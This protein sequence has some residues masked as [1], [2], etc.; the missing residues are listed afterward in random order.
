M[1][2]LKKERLEDEPREQEKNSVSGERKI[3][4]EDMNNI[5][6]R[7]DAEGRTRLTPEEGELLVEYHR[8]IGQ[9]CKEYFQKHPTPLLLKY[10][11][12]REEE[13]KNKTT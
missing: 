13:E 1:E 9:E 8:Q 6:R 7:M 4:A 5:R 3:T 2:D 10:M 12:L 11:K